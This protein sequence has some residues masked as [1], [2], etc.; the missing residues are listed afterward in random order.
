MSEIVNSTATCKCFHCETLCYVPFLQGKEIKEK[1]VLDLFVLYF[2]WQKIADC[3][4]ISA[5]NIQSDNRIYG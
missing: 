1:C 4:I 2:R 3:L 5:M